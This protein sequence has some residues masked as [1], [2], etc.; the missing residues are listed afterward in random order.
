MTWQII[1]LLSTRIFAQ[2][3]SLQCGNLLRRNIY[4]NTLIWFWLHLSGLQTDYGGFH[5]LVQSKWAD[6]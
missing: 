4:A 3:M 1:V 6:T 2:M 5:F